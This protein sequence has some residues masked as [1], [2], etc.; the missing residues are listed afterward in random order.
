MG[1]N[2]LNNYVGMVLLS[3]HFCFALCGWLGLPLLGALSIFGAFTASLI[4]D[5]YRR[6]EA[7]GAAV[8]SYAQ[9]GT[10]CMGR[11]GMWLVII[12]STI[13][14]FFA[15]LCMN[16]IAWTNASL[17]LPTL[18]LSYVIT[19]MVLLSFPT[20]RIRDFSVLSFLSYL[21]MASVVLIIAIV[22]S[23]LS[24]IAE[25]NTTQV[26][27]KWDGLPMSASMMLAGLSGHVGIPP[28]Y[29]EM[30]TPS[31]FKRVLGFS[32]VVIFVMYATVG[33]VGYMLYGSGS[34]VLITSDMIQ[35]GGGGAIGSVLLSLVLFCITFK[36]FCSVPLL[37]IVLVDVAQNMYKESTGKALSVSRSNQ[38]RLGIWASTTALSGV[39][40]DSLQYATALIGI[41]SM[42]ISVVLPI[43]FYVM[44]HQKDMGV[45]ERAAY[46][47]ILTFA[48]LFTM[49]ISYMDVQEFIESLHGKVSAHV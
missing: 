4:V 40:F 43:L 31:A 49:M 21:G 36:L 30:K 24:V 8:P 27:A 9:I 28:M 2:L 19:G 18:P 46:A 10:A 23:K 7:D 14:L 17:L 29:A 39:L 13:E 38:L 33:V 47:A 37:I 15:V 20:N 42:V 22:V 11:F 32:F 12:S 3:N 35:A 45:L 48:I 16:I 6:I 26:L 5:S 1:F 34:N 41:N 44:L 25:P